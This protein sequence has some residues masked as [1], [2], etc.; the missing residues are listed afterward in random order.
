M[1]WATR[2]GVD[3]FALFVLENTS[4]A[5]AELVLTITTIAVALSILAHGVTAAPFARWYGAMA[6]RMGECE[7][8]RPVSEMPTRSGPIKS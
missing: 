4:I 3:L 6:A 7:E 5:A 1:V 2:P 8:K